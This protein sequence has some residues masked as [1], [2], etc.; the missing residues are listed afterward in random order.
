MEGKYRDFI[1][2]DKVLKFMPVGGVRIEDNVLITDKGH[3]VLGKAIPKTVRE[4]ET[5]CS[6]YQS[7]Q[8]F[9]I[10]GKVP[11]AHGSILS[12]CRPS[13]REALHPAC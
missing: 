7:F 3:K 10:P 4:I 11:L 9:S 13:G 6:D 5:I 1:N 8:G 12:I 2:Y